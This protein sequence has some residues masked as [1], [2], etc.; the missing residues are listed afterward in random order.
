VQ[1]ILVRFAVFASNTISMRNDV[2]VVLAHSI[3]LPR[4]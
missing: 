3:P 2:V 4:E 1:S